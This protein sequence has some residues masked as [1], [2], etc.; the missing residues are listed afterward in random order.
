MKQVTAYKLS[1]GKLTE[2]LEEAVKDEKLET[3][4]TKLG[5]LDLYRSTDDILDNY[6]ELEK[7]FTEDA[8]KLLNKAIN[9][10]NFQREWIKN[11]KPEISDSGTP[12]LVFESITK[13]LSKFE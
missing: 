12:K 10:I 7:I 11:V 6:E 1:G 3:L 2:S 8:R 4:K 5:S 9:V 13:Y